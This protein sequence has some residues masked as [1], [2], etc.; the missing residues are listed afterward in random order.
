M[1]ILKKEEFLVRQAKSGKSTGWLKSGSAELLSHSHVKT[2]MIYIHVLNRGPS[3]VRSP[4]EGW[5][6]G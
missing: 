5:D 4:A 2:T 3:G 1:L 6:S